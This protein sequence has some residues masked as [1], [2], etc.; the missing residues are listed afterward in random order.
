MSN[1]RSSRRSALV[2]F[3]AAMVLPSA[4]HADATDEQ[5]AAVRELGRQG[6]AASMSGDC[7]TAVDRL[8]RAEAILHVPSLAE[9]LAECQIKLG[10]LVEGT[11]ILQRLAH[12]ALPAGAPLP[13]VA[14]MQKVAPLI[15]ETE[16]RIPKLRVHVARPEGTKGE[17]AVTIDGEALS[18]ALIDS[19]RPTDPGGHRIVARQPGC[20]DASVEVL[21]KEGETREV[22]LQ[23]RP[24]PTPAAPLPAPGAALPGATVQDARPEAA[25]SR[26]P[27][28]IALGAGVAGLA[29]GSVYGAFAL[30][31]KS[32]L[33]A[34]CRGGACPASL[35][36]QIDQMHANAIASTVGFGVAAA[37]AA[38]GT[39][40][41][42]SER[43]AREGSPQ[44]LRVSPQ[45][46]VGSVGL[47]GSFQ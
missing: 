16:P 17:L 41:F 38:L 6:I 33:D 18:A 32:Q 21:L 20:A 13:W 29:V 26:V 35:S 11:E 3:I 14:A 47:T 7:A 30:V 10:R 42:L 19:D 22:S 15:E 9:P 28:F 23:L 44:G 8:G 1:R 34:S 27:A 4:A 24:V 12:E 40:L 43:P 2:A 36:P 31:D 45:V 39:F 37:G 5:R 46:G 25:P